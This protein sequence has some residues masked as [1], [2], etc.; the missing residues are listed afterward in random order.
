MNEIYHQGRLKPPGKALIS[1]LD[2]GLLFG[3]SL[4]ETF[5]VYGGKPLFFK[6][7]VE[8]LRRG[9]RLLH[10]PYL[11]TSEFKKAIGL[12]TKK[13]P[14]THSFMVRFNLTQELVPPAGPRTFTFRRPVTFATARPLRHDIQAPQPPSGKAGI[15]PWKTPHWRMFPTRFKTASY[16]TTR[17]TFREHPD[18][19][20]ILKLNDR[21]QVVDGGGAT[22]F[23]YD[24]KSL[25]VPPLNLGGLESVT[26]KKVISL[27]R[28]LG[29]KVVERPWKPAQVSRKGELFL[30][31]SGVALLRV[32]HLQ[33]RP[34]KPALGLTSRLWRHYQGW[35]TT[36]T[37]FEF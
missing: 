22:P 34:L 21:G 24:G 1:P 8:R 26:R 28:R 33:G 30:A 27:C 20:E 25:W 32:T 9:C 5:P 36:N 31:G 14:K 11:P 13:Y 2:T 17:L 29:L 12:F 4:F 37:H 35:A 23:W 19:D 15:S 10:W 6:D 16:L 18:W 3:E 7:H